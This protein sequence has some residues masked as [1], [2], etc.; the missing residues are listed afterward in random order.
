MS[1]AGPAPDAELVALLRRLLDMASAPLDKKALYNGLEKVECAEERIAITK[2]LTL[3]A[4][5]AGVE[6]TD[7]G[8]A[9]S[10]S[11]GVMA[12]V[13]ACVRTDTAPLLQ[14]PFDA[15]AVAQRMIGLAR[16]LRAVEDTKVKGDEFREVRAYIDMTRA[17]V[18]RCIDLATV[19]HSLPVDGERG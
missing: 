4:E 1:R 5:S 3:I 6:S 18:T 13:K 14:L 17:R 7:H 2:M 8:G 15:A 9:R 12:A 19:Q 11:A 16:A 10:A